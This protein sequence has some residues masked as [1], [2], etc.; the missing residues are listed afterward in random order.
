ML[1][2]SNTTK[3]RL[4]FQFL[5]T[6]CY[7]F[8][9]SGFTPVTGDGDVKIIWR[10]D[11]PPNAGT[12]CKEF[13]TKKDTANHLE[14]PKEA[15]SILMYCRTYAHFMF[16]IEVPFESLFTPIK[17]FARYSLDEGKTF[18]SGPD[19]F[20]ETHLTASSNNT[21]T[22]IPRLTYAWGLHTPS[23]FHKSDLNKYL[24]RSICL[25]I[26]IWMNNMNAV[27]VIPNENTS[28][29]KKNGA[30]LKS[31]SPFILPM[32]LLFDDGIEDQKE[33]ILISYI[34]SGSAATL[35]CNPFRNSSE[36]FLECRF[37]MHLVY[38]L[39][40]K[41]SVMYIIQAGAVYNFP[42]VSQIQKVKKQRI[43]LYTD[44][45]KQ[46]IWQNT[47]NTFWEHQFSNVTDD[48]TK[49][50]LYYQTFQSGVDEKFI[51]KK[52]DLTKLIQDETMLRVKS[53]L[54]AKIDNNDL[55]LTSLDPQ[56][57]EPIWGPTVELKV[58]L[59]QLEP[60][61]TPYCPALS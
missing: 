60:F 33:N 10:E 16:E 22:S 54:W 23:I 12:I 1:S 50:S 24:P 41:S 8:V 34:E 37:N 38:K 5:L 46:D 36:E 25:E 14:H 6:L 13:N 11:A 39:R 55:Y 29:E 57:N 26:G 28:N 59:Q 15:D 51:V 49:E 35:W 42:L 20:F 44:D 61:H 48:I 9:L 40:P 53:K 45:N 2:K 32:P 18:I 43:S 19:P 52:A 21:S 56:E 31:R 27:S 7:I 17:T 47:D 30:I 58:C 3:K 4:H